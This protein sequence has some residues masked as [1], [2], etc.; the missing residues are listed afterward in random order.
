MNWDV[1]IKNQIIT[2]DYSWCDLRLSLPKLCQGL[3][4]DK[5][6]YSDG[7]KRKLSRCVDAENKLRESSRANA[8]E[9][10]RP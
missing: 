10:R 3:V 7:Y 5:G 8:S 2:G 6:C 1:L 4:L 9:R